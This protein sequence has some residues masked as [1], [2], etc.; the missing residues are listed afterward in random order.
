[1]IALERC[2][3]SATPDEIKKRQKSV[4]NLKYRL[5]KNADSI[6]G[7]RYLDDLKDFIQRNLIQHKEDIDA[8]GYFYV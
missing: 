2:V 3:E 1:L 6:H 8:K 5:K 4:S 7:M